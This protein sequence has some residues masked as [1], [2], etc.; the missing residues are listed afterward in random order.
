MYKMIHDQALKNKIWIKEIDH[1][2]TGSSIH[3]K[4]E[5]SNFTTSTKHTGLFHEHGSTG[6]KL[7][8]IKY[9]YLLFFFSISSFNRFIKIINFWNSKSNWWSHKIK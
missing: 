8:I 5:P 9:T 1:L 4:E 2:A 3:Q 7:Y 6:S